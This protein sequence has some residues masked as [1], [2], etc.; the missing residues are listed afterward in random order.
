MGCGIEGGRLG[1][2]GSVVWQAVHRAPG[3]TEPRIESCGGDGKLCRRRE[4][5]RLMALGQEGLGFSSIPFL[6]AEFVTLAAVGR[7]RPKRGCK[8]ACSG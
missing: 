7:A 4:Q 1:A 3:S 5:R 2:G 6:L 8:R